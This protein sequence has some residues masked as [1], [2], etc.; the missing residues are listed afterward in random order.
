MLVQRFTNLELD[1]A[2]FREQL[3]VYGE[4]QGIEDL[5]GEELQSDS[6]R[7]SR[8]QPPE[9][10]PGMY[11]LASPYKSVL[12]ALGHALFVYSPMSGEMLFWY[13]FCQITHIAGEFTFLHL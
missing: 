3:H 11:H 13:V 7:V 1:Q 4:A 5:L 9:R 8:Y 12:E 2:R 6:F 10:S